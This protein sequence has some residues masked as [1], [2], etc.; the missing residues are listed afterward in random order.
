MKKEQKTYADISVTHFGSRAD[1]YEGSD[2]RRVG[3]SSSQTQTA[4]FNVFLNLLLSAESI[5]DV[6][7]G[8]GDL[9]AFLRGHGYR[10]S[11]TGVDIIN[12]NCQTAESRYKEADF[13]PANVLE[14]KTDKKYDYVVAS[15]IFGIKSSASIWESNTTESL[16]KMFS[17]CKIGVLAN[18]LS[19]YAD[20]EN[21]YSYHVSVGKIADICAENLTKNFQIQH[22]YSEKGNDFT[23]IALRNKR[24]KDSIS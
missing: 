19:K 23:L 5:L 16:V 14:W 17:M 8:V 1:L 9:F 24:T 2:I 18:F 12:S 22:D 7:C 4:R 11:Y 15:G 3:W 21:D 6:G 13:I 10:G 20:V